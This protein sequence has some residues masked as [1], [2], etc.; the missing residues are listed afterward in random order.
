MFHRT[1]VFKYKEN[2]ERMKGLV[3]PFESWEEG[4]QG[5]QSNSLVNTAEKTV[6]LSPLPL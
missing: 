4:G 6:P 3:A 5:M 2:E 1:N